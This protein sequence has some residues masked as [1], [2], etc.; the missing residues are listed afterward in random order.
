MSAKTH[1]RCARCGESKHVATYGVFFTSR[2]GTGWVSRHCESCLGFSGMEGESETLREEL[3]EREEE[4]LTLKEKVRELRTAI[5]SIEKG[6]FTV[7]GDE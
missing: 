7:G 3:K 6:T 1:K 5:R 2:S 4:L